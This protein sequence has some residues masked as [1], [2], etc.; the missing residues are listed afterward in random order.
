MGQPRGTD[1]EADY[2]KQGNKENGQVN[3]LIGTRHSIRCCESLDQ[4]RYGCVTQPRRGVGLNIRQRGNLLRQ[5]GLGTRWTIVGN[6]VWSWSGYFDV[7][8]FIDIPRLP[9][10]QM[11]G[12]SRLKPKMVRKRVRFSWDAFSKHDVA[13][14][15]FKNR[16]FG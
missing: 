3:P 16:S 15:R 9:L 5:V 6:G 10:R 11:N 12:E 13:L 2:D 8:R 14:H 1:S 7:R 4:S